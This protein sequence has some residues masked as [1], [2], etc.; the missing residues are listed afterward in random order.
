M[1]AHRA[2]HQ[3]NVLGDRRV[4][5]I[6]RRAPSQH[7]E[8]QSYHSES[9]ERDCS[10]SPSSKL[11]NLSIV[12]MMEPRTKILTIATLAIL[13]LAACNGSS[14]NQPMGSGGASPSGGRGSGG[15]PSNGGSSAPVD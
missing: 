7:F 10:D 8:G 9:K 3:G 2:P 6:A 1:P 14:N 12:Q 4:Q 5:L 11:K 13:A 15:K